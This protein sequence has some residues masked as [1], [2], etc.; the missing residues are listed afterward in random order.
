MRIHEAPPQSAHEAGPGARE[1]E[2]DD[3]ARLTEIMDVLVAIASQDFSRR[4]TVGDGSHL[5]D[6]IAAGLNMLAEEA[7]K[8]TR[9]EQEHRRRIAHAERLAAV[10]QLAASVAHEVNNPAAFVLTNLTAMEERLAN[11]ESF[12]GEM[13]TCFPRGGFPDRRVAELLARSG[14][15]AGLLES[16]RILEDC[17]SGVQRIVS[18]VKDLRGFARAPDAHA[19]EEVSLTDVCEDACKLVAHEV[20]YRAR[21]VK[22][23]EPTPR[24]LANR[25]QLTQVLTNLLLNAAQAIQEGDRDNNEV[26]LTTGVEGDRVFVR[27]RDT[28]AGIPDDVR[29][30]LFEPFFTTK[31]GDRGT[32]LGLA[33]SSE[34]VRRHRGELRFESTPGRGTVFE[35]WLP[36]ETG[37][38]RVS[39]PPAPVPVTDARLKVLIID[40]EQ[41]LLVAYQ[42]LFGRRYDLSLAKGGREAVELLE[43][44]PRWD[45]ILCDIMMPDLDGAAVYEWVQDHRPELL[46]RLGFCTGGVF[47]PRSR[48]LAER[49]A[50]RLFEKPLSRGQVMAAVEELR[51]GANA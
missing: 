26:E 9:V 35:V 36:V 46:R 48:A 21:C 5:L 6:G 8:Q 4:A 40:D 34:I 25:N 18:I 29:P 50:G 2:H 7:H 10:G 30:R 13:R 12:V 14:A 41:E 49:V 43:R 32:G 19:P 1:A 17:V 11:L 24:I 27:V 47:T 45:A 16:R 22:R 33:V 37:L 20:V 23:F 31:P 28:G 42:R 51:S 44:D 38:A 15:D 39:A 3:G